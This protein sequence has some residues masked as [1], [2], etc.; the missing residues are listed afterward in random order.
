MVSTM[1]FKQ[2]FIALEAMRPTPRAGLASFVTGTRKWPGDIR[3]VHGK[4]RHA[5]GEV[6]ARTYAEAQSHVVIVNS[7]K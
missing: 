1:T 6:M 3:L 7:D 5:L 4:P 2:V